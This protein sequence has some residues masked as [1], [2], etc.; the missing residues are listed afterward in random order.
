[1]WVRECTTGTDFLVIDCFYCLRSSSLRFIRTSLG[2]FPTPALFCVSLPPVLVD[3]LVYCLF[4]LLDAFCIL[5][6]TIDKVYTYRLPRLCVP[7]IPRFVVAS[8]VS[9]YLIPRF[10]R[11]VFGASYC[12]YHHS[13][14]VNDHIGSGLSTATLGNTGNRLGR[15]GTPPS[16]KCY[17]IP[18]D[19]R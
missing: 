14:P 11:Y 19:L 16:G 2:P 1:V 10:L 9:H 17:K 13:D 15:G 18:K 12:T 4:N 3:P 8:V 6:P 7:I 5:H